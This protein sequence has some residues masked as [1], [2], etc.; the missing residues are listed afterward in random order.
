LSSLILIS[1]AELMTVLPVLLLLLRLLWS[2]QIF[3]SNPLPPTHCLVPAPSPS[4]HSLPTQGLLLLRPQVGWRQTHTSP[5][6]PEIQ[7]V[8]FILALYQ[9]T[10]CVSF[11][12]DLIPNGSQRLSPPAF[13]SSTHPS[14]EDSNTSRHLPVKTIAEQ[15]SK[16]YNTANHN[17]WQS[18]EETEIRQQDTTQ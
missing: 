10:C 14:V 5:T 6:A 4:R 3:L 16:T 9:E 8:I 18:R 2:P 1:A 15:A 17:L 13:L 11:L 7:P 12:S